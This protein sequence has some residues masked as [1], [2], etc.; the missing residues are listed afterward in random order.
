MRMNK[1]VH[2]VS[3]E[4]L[5]GKIYWR[6]QH[7][8]PGKIDGE[9]IY[10]Q[11]SH[12]INMYRYDANDVFNI[13][14]DGE[15]PGFGL[16]PDRGH[17]V[18]W[19]GYRSCLTMLLYLNGKEQGVEGGS[20]RLYRRDRTWCDVEPRKGSALFFR[21]GYGTDSVLHEGR[22]VVGSTPKYVARINVLYRLG[23]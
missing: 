8:L 21:H 18:E 14:A 17:M 15:W 5:L 4:T 10:E 3:D 1:S 7:L 6:I 19:P 12:R 23:G 13:H 20:T 11:F 9:Q 22:R 16:S 2:W